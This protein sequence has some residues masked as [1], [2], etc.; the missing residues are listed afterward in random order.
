MSLLHIG[1]IITLYSEGFLST[2]GLVDD[3]CVLHPCPKDPPKKFRDCLF[4][5]CIQHKY[6]VQ[7]ELWRSGHVDE[8]LYKKLY[9]AAKLE[10][11]TNQDKNLMKRGTVVKYED[12]VQL[13]H[14][15]SNKYITVNAKAAAPEEDEAT[16]VYL[17]SNGN[18]GSWFKV[19]SP[20]KYRSNGEDVVCESIALVSDILGAL[21]HEDALYLHASHCRLSDNPEVLEINA[22]RQSTSWDVKPFLDYTEDLEDFLKGG[23]VVRLF[24]TDQEKFLTMDTYN[25]EDTQHVFLRSTDRAKATS[26]TSSKALWEVEVVH[27]DPCRG[28][29][30]RWNSL[31]RLK[32]L[33]TERFLAADQDDDPTPDPMREKLRVKGAPVFK[34]ISIEFSY[35]FATLFEFDSTTTNVN[36]DDYIPIQS[37]ITL[38]HHP[39]GTYVHSTNIY[40]DND[41]KKKSMSKVGCAQNKGLDEVFAV[42]PVSATEIR[43]LDFV[44]D[45]CLLLNEAHDL[46]KES[47]STTNNHSQDGSEGL[48]LGS[49]SNKSL[50]VGRREAHKK[51]S[52]LL[53]EILHFIANKENEPRKIEKALSMSAE[54][55]NRERQKLL[56][57]QN[58]L[59]LLI[60]I[61][62]LEDS[63]DELNFNKDV[64]R[65]CY[66][67]LS[68]SFQ[69][70]RKNQEYI[71]SSEWDKFMQRQ[72]G[73]DIFA[74]LT[75][76]SLF[77]ANIKLLEKRVNSCDIE[78]FVKLIRR[79]RQSQI[80]DCLSD[81]CITSN[82]SVSVQTQKIISELILSGENEDILVET[83]Y[84]DDKIL[85]STQHWRAN[86]IESMGEFIM[87]PRSLRDIVLAAKNGYE[88]E[89]FILDYYR[90]QLDLF[91][92]LCVSRQYGA[93][94]IL[95]EKLP[96]SLIQQ[97]VSDAEL[98]CGL[99]ASFCRLLLHLYLIRDPRMPVSPVRNEFSWRDIPDKIN[100]EIYDRHNEISG[101]GRSV[102][103]NTS[104]QSSKDANDISQT[105]GEAETASTRTHRVSREELR[106]DFSEAMDF[107][108][109]YLSDLVLLSSAKSYSSSVSSIFNNAERNKLTFEVINLTRE[110]AYFGFYKLSDFLRLVEILLVILEDNRNQQNLVMK[111]KTKIIE[112]LHYMSEVRL[113]YMVT[114]LLSIFKS[115]Q[116]VGLTAS[117]LNTG[118][119]QGIGGNLSPSADSSSH[120]AIKTNQALDQYLNEVNLDSSQGRK[121]VN[122]LLHLLRHD[123]PELVSASLKLLLNYRAQRNRT[124]ETYKKIS[125]TNVT[126]QI[127]RNFRKLHP[128]IE[129]S[130]R[131]IRRGKDENHVAVNEVLIQDSKLI[132]YIVQ[133]IKY[134]LKNTEEGSLT[135]DLLRLL[136]DLI[137]LDDLHQI[138]QQQQQKAKTSKGRRKEGE[139]MSPEISLADIQNKLDSHGTSS[140][141]VELIAMGSSSCEEKVRQRSASVFK[142]TLA[143]GI[144]LLDGG[145]PSIQASIHDKL[146]RKGELDKSERFFE[147]LSTRMNIAQ[148]ALSP[149]TANA[150]TGGS[151]SNSGSLKPSASSN[152]LANQQPALKRFNG[153]HPRE[154]TSSMSVEYSSPKLSRQWS[155][156]APG[157]RL[158]INESLKEDIEA[159]VETTEKAL[160]KTRANA[161]SSGLQPHDKDF[162]DFY[163]ND[164]GY[165][166]TPTPNEELAFSDLDKKSNFDSSDPNHRQIS[167]G[168]SRSR[169]LPDVIKIM[170]PIL[171]FLQLLCE[172]HNLTMQN[173]VRVQQNKTSYNLVAQTLVFLNCICGSKEGSLGHKLGEYINEGN[174]DLINQTLRTLTEYCQGPCIE[175]QRCILMHESNGI[176][177][178]RS[179]ILDN[180]EPLDNLRMDL[181]IELKDNASKLLLALMESCQDPHHAGRILREPSLTRKLIDVAINYYHEQDD[182]DDSYTELTSVCG[183]SSPS[184]ISGILDG[185]SLQTSG[186]GSGSGSLV[187]SLMSQGGL[188]SDGIIRPRDVGHKV[189]ILCHQLVQQYNMIAPNS[190]LQARIPTSDDARTREKSLTDLQSQ[191][192]SSSN[193]ISS[194]STS[195]TI[196]ERDAIAL[197]YY[198]SH[199]AQIEIV[200]GN[201]EMERV[202]FPVPQICE[203]LTRETKSDVYFN[204]EQDERGSKIPNFFQSIEDLFEEMKWQRE[205]QTK[206][207]LH[208][209]A[210]YMS[211]WSDVEF[212]LS[213][214]VTVL[215]LFCVSKASTTATGGSLI[216]QK[217]TLTQDPQQLTPPIVASAST[218]MPQQQSAGGGHFLPSMLSTILAIVCSTFF[219]FKPKIPHSWTLFLICATI[220]L[221]QVVGQCIS[222]KIL[223]L[224][225]EGVSMMHLF[226]VLVNKGYVN[227][228]LSSIFSESDVI[229]HGSYLMVCTLGLLFNPLFYPF[230]LPPALI[231]REETLRN[232]I[233]S[234]TK[235]AYSILMTGFLGLIIILLYTI[236]VY[237]FYGEDFVIDLEDDST[238]KPCLGTLWECYVAHVNYGLRDG[239]GIGERIRDIRLDLSTLNI[240][241][242]M[243][244]IS[245]FLV[246]NLLI[247]QLVYCI[248][249]DSFATLRSEKQSKDEVL[250]NT[251][252]VCGL[253][254]S[255][256][257]NRTVTFEEHIQIEH[258]LWHYLYFIVLIKI[259]SRTELS[260]PESYVYDMIKSKD[261]SWF[262]RMRAM[263]LIHTDQ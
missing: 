210:R 203:Y 45:A 6:D 249:V 1:D 162:V 61:L 173:Y 84:Q 115:N 196:T 78:K 110:L 227:K 164:S 222:L 89:L 87:P 170:R 60:D 108:E 163:N 241:R 186:G 198:E 228:P 259:K 143:L 181:V 213:F 238:Y 57:E 177:M 224:C 235:N 88:L 220:Y 202:V 33:A 130:D 136:K 233:K 244:I 91:S 172:D 59:K 151:G 80:L 252:F 64:C 54:N 239:G 139:Q 107:V 200:R 243:F 117:S 52:E 67:V 219:V 29:L 234:V 165:S 140:L 260:G 193:S 26:A 56:R 20:Y 254:R 158:V 161:N 199:T 4:K 251:C 204:T 38:K 119:G 225:L 31:I 169:N 27:P 168:G 135:M 37:N 171:R 92:A 58:V 246:V 16:R 43:D 99:R 127:H 124:L 189:F 256:F 247:L 48:F 148:Q 47:L 69:D 192:S 28:S 137:P 8:E 97:C 11:D 253:D 3:R 93:I 83:L 82:Q 19:R 157:E 116:Q 63:V 255:S 207:L 245:F 142:D 166:A 14:I 129:R 179:L 201:R 105:Q 109:L 76:S 132:S 13:L 2:L 182:Y 257:E 90:H 96:M 121:F 72:F 79:K 176:D 86:Q 100:V 122:V 68:L 229:Y 226:S 217:I 221:A 5:V 240:V 111:T 223:G 188:S 36:K 55:P 194:S 214:F 195:N 102:S 184:D 85:L 236:I 175:N 141:V 146:T 250:R 216:G 154:Y 22:S 191:S 147:V 70:Y 71:V 232:V 205:L 9:T 237:L 81:M 77:H 159:T 197:R 25:N 40:I 118:T 44:Y 49:E 215:V 95:S 17:D 261:Y 131:Y 66:R 30:G 35:D 152:S 114:S 145:N 51:L 133:H 126:Q 211:I 65:L 120:I 128:L 149:T 46:I 74:E 248:I 94:R 7:G 190:H 231:R 160:A 263:S 209:I 150:T 185:S 153:M 75:Y 39:T 218:Q 18:E 101:I 10:Q 24:H 41:K 98:H 134:L 123:C 125:L 183:D 23:D 12:T 113:D 167:A 21:S 32:H 155:L 187:G 42:I 208:S 156:S 73:K 34:L 138:H 15:K 112:I 206:P 230:L 50:L 212:K 104:T 242:I 178:I 262:P 180:I 174:V 106:E 103:S 62:E 258:N 144:A 53:P